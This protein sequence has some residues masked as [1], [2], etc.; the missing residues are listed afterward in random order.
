MTKF[1]GISFDTASAADRSSICR[2]IIHDPDI[3]NDE[4]FGID[5]GLSHADFTNTKHHG[6][7]PKDVAGAQ[8]FSQFFFKT[9]FLSY[10]NNPEIIFTSYNASFDYGVLKAACEK[11][12][13]EMP[14]N[15]WLCALRASRRTWPKA[16][17]YRAATIQDL[18]DTEAGVGPT[19]PSASL[20]GS[21]AMFAQEIADMVGFILED[22]YLPGNP[23]SFHGYMTFSEFTSTYMSREKLITDESVRYFS[24][25][26]AVFTGGVPGIV[27]TDAHK[28]VIA[29]GGKPGSAVTGYT[30]I[31]IDTAMEAGKP[32]TEK[33]RLF[34][35]NQRYSR[36]AVLMPGSEFL[37]IFGLA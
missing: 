11:Y 2:V 25:R 9:D 4:I 8:T 14:T 13:L 34:V 35:T 32:Q 28:M 31:L 5:P 26:N 22:E 1:V 23:P 30:H 15:K 27:R 21:R 24:S 12:G 36:E 19:V 7:T 17:N 29:S 33:E 3:D 10:I 6:I 37:S 16:D 18:I 20:R